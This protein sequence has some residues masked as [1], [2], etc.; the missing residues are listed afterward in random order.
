MELNND[1]LLKLYGKSNELLLSFKNESLESIKSMFSNFGKH[2]KDIFIENIFDIET[3]SMLFNIKYLNK[4]VY[5]LLSIE[6]D[7]NSRN[8]K[9]SFS[10]FIKSNDYYCILI[11]KQIEVLKYIKNIDLLVLF[12]EYDKY[13][14]SYK[15]NIN[16]ITK[17]YLET[18][19]MRATIFAYSTIPKVGD[20]YYGI[21]KDSLNIVSWYIK[22]ISSRNTTIIKKEID[23]SRTI[24][25]ESVVIN[26]TNILHIILRNNIIYINRDE[27]DTALNEFIEYRHETNVDIID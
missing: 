17:V 2:T 8:I 19:R 11:D 25:N 24:K 18:V 16:K 21:N 14:K 6:Y 9:Y 15:R 4:R 22:S 3:N 26:S 1:E 20:T 7:F 27:V 10:N 13:I 5:N 23:N 12:S